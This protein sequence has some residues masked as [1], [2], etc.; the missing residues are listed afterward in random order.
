M[1][2]GLYTKK[3]R[4]RIYIYSWILCE[5]SKGLVILALNFQYGYW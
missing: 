2:W 4:K 5:G 1:S 3:T